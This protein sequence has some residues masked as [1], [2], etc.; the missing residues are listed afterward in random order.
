M[1]RQAV[2]VLSIEIVVVPTYHV[3]RKERLQCK[4]G[5]VPA[6]PRVVSLQRAVGRHL[7]GMHT[8]N[9]KPLTLIMPSVGHQSYICESAYT[10]CLGSS[11][12]DSLLVRA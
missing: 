5:Y 2:I 3:T 11:A 1:F 6:L 8:L 12:K 7:H 9:H 10:A 4:T